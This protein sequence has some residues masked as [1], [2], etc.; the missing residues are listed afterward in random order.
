MKSVQ[1]TDLERVLLGCALGD[2]LGLPF[3][4]LSPKKCSRLLPKELRHTL[5]FGRGMLS[6]DTEHSIFVIDAFNRSSN[7]KD[8][9]KIMRSHLR[10]WFLCCPPG[11]GLGTLKSCLKMLFG[12]KKTSVNSAGNGP[13]M[14][15]A[16]LAVLLKNQPE[17]LAEYIKANTY[18][19]HADERAFETSYLLAKLVLKNLETR[20]TAND[21]KKESSSIQNAEFK[22]AINVMVECLENEKTPDEYLESAGLLKGVSGYCIH[23]FCAAVYAV[24]YFKNDLNK[25]ISWCIRSGG[26][27]DSAAAVAGA[28][29]SANPECELPEDHLSGIRD[30]PFSINFMKGLTSGTSKLG[31]FLPKMALRNLFF[32]PLIL[33]LA[34]IRIFR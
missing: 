23:T 8:Y 10:K 22:A 15:T 29:A 31:F 5:F 24:I 21:L 12:L 17:K 2:S 14:R 27:T 34:I 7:E 25:I 18:L 1:Q 16:V 26:D 20:L 33:L 30:W 28:L 6:D 13:L 11:I 19:S 32:I 9:L 3:E 4:G